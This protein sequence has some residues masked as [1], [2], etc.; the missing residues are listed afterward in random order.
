MLKYALKKKRLDFMEGLFTPEADMLVP[1][2][3][4][5]DLLAQLSSSRAEDNVMDT[6]IAALG[7]GE[8]DVI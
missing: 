4:E 7:Q 1:Q 2:D 3:D 5:A 6:I 8:E